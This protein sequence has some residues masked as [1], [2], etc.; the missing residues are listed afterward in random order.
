MYSLDSAEDIEHSIDEANHPKSLR[1]EQQMEES[2]QSM[3]R[4]ARFSESHAGNYSNSDEDIS[5]VTDDEQA[6]GTNVVHIPNT[7]WMLLMNSL[8]V[9]QLS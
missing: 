7:W 3:H 1:N 8:R 6:P 4:M 5:A 9:L 2:D